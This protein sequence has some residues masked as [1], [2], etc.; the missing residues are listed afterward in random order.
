MVPSHATFT[1]PKPQPH[2]ALWCCVRQ[3]G[4]GGEEETQ[5]E[6]VLPGDRGMPGQQLLHC[7]CGYGQLLAPPG[8]DPP[9]HQRP[10]Q[11]P[12]GEEGANPAGVAAGRG[13]EAENGARRR[14]GCRPP[15]RKAQVREEHRHWHLPALQLHGAPASPAALQDPQPS[16]SRRGAAPQSRQAHHQ[17]ALQCHADLRENHQLS[18]LPTRGVNSCLG[19]YGLATR[20]CVGAV[21]DSGSEVKRCC[22]AENCMHLPWELCGPHLLNRALV[23]AVGWTEGGREGEREGQGV[24]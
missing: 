14:G 5:T 11:R 4:R 18:S 21:S 16:L 9:K 3:A 7:G 1:K 23:N 17:R 24:F 20:Y 22:M 19:E 10:Q 13:E 8:G 2:L 15:P 12:E 6:G